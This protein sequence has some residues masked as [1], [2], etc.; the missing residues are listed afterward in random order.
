MIS[1]NTTG[2]NMEVQNLSEAIIQSKN[3]PVLANKF[4]IFAGKGRAR[5]LFNADNKKATTVAEGS[6]ITPD[7]TIYSEIVFQQKRVASAVDMSKALVNDTAEV[8]VPEIKNVLATRVLREFAGQAFG[9]GSKDGS[10]VDK[11]QS[12]LD[13]NSQTAGKVNATDIKEF[14]GVT[15]ANI[16]SAYGE[17]AADNVGEAVIV[18]D[19]LATVNALVDGANQPLLKKENRLDGAIG[20]I[21]GIPVHIQDMN[22]K[23]KFVLLNPKAY[24]VCVFDSSEFK[25]TAN[26]IG[27]SVTVTADTYAMGK[28]VDPNGIKIIK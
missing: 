2:L 12:I 1:T 24:A 4:N 10:E 5:R 15:V 27:G 9:F 6:S 8:I 19:A 17:F 20:T 25:E 7:D 28:V 18:I 22:A 13:Y 3:V 11:F 16:D 21:Y 14:T 26:P 23:A